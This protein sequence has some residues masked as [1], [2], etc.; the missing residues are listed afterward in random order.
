MMLF[1]TTAAALLPLLALLASTAGA[2]A[3]ASWLFGL[4]R[5]WYP[6]PPVPAVSL[7]WR[8]VFRVLYAPR[9]ARLFVLVLASLVS[10]VASV[11]VAL[12]TGVAVAGIVDA[13]LAASLAAIVSQLLHGLSLDTEVPQSN[14][15]D[16]S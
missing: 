9:Y 7:Y 2:G 15:E 3:V 11:G 16:R 12:I 13:A 1:P 6:L 10:L 5:S 8:V 14:S 4:L